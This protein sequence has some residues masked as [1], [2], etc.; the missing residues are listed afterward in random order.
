MLRMLE[1]RKIFSDS[2]KSDLTDEPPEGVSSEMWA[3]L[4]DSGKE[5]MKKTVTEAKERKAREE[6]RKEESKK[7]DRS[8]SAD[9]VSLDT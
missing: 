5:A 6:Q 4:D 8:L 1:I 7:R 3:L 2:A 9:D